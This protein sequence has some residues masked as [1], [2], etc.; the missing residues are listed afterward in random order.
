MRV[1]LCARDCRVR[2]IALGRAGP[3]RAWAVIQ[4]VWRREEGLEDIHSLE[5]LVRDGLLH[6]ASELLL[7]PVEVAS[8]CSPSLF[9][10]ECESTRADAVYVRSPSGP[11]VHACAGACSLA[12]GGG[13]TVH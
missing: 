5:V 3:A 8:R 10:R 7:S 13:G 4:R 2:V 12:G 11:C 9:M 1:H 6:T